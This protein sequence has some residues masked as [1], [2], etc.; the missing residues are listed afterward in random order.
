MIKVLLVEDDLTLAMGI[1]YSLEKEGYDVDIDYNFEKGK[2][3]IDN[4]NMI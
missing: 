1:E 3:F 2:R 4:K